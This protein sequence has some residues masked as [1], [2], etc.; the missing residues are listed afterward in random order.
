[1]AAAACVLLLGMF[2]FSGC[3]TV[4]ENQPVVSGE[5]QGT[6]PD[7]SGKT[8]TSRSY[9]K[10]EKDVPDTLNNEERTERPDV[11]K[12][13]PN[14]DADLSRTAQKMSSPKVTLGKKGGAFSGQDEPIRA[15]FAFDNADIHEV[16]DVI[17]YEHFNLSYMMDPAIRAKLS[18]HI[19]GEFTKKE[20][21]NRLNSIF[22]LSNLAIV[23]GAGNIL[24]IVN[25]KD[26]PG[27]G[28]FQNY[29]RTDYAGDIT[30]LIKL[31]YI[32]APTAE[33]H[34]KPFLSPAALSIVDP[35]NNSLIITDMQENIEKATTILGFMDEPFFQDL[36]WKIFPIEEGDSKKVANDLNGMLKS[37][38]FYTRAGMAQGGYHIIPLTTIN[39]VFVLSRWP[40]V[41]RM[42]EKWISVMDR[43]GEAGAGVYVYFVENSSAK[44]LADI[45]KQ[46]YGGEVRKNSTSKSQKIV[47]SEKG[48]EQ[49]SQGETIVSGEL[50]GE[51][52]IIPD[53][54]TNSLIFKAGR[55]DYAKISKVLNKLDI[56]SRQVL[57]NVVVAEV[58]LEET[59]EY[60][61]QWYL[62]D[63]YG[64]YSGQGML[65]IK[66]SL[67][68]VNSALG[69]STQFTYSIF[70]SADVL[71]GLVSALGKESD[72]NI[73]SSPNV[74][75][76]DNKAARIEVGEDVPTITGQVTDAN[77]GV[78]NTVQ[79]KKTGIILEVT[80]HINS[81]GLVKMELV[82][83]VSEKGSLDQE[84]QNYSILNRKVETNLVVE[85][86]QTILMGGMMKS[87]KSNSESGIPFVK[88]LPFVGYLFKGTTDEV[89]KTELIFLITPHVV[90]N[91][92]DADRI[93]REFSSKIEGVK[94]LL[95]KNSDS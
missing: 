50:S 88:D 23:R 67:K 92:K 58:T 63:H 39:A 4:A 94:K 33:Q 51:V 27:A 64:D 17:L 40:E 72:I 25:R 26:V 53:E 32:G 54:T 35:V 16:V 5:V 95:E 79:Y 68:T 85:D 77:G 56:V 46:V 43:Q 30:R 83:E 87:N 28:N 38:G 36:S 78:T 82:Q 22:Q 19:A 66:D 34:I 61:I 80:P 62:K 90:N 65:D 11:D 93:T 8:D 70:N 71:K 31:R 55:S 42:A 69:A 81:S 37:K 75:A 13:F 14:P 47:S 15:E 7:T 74:L 12:K 3:V 89:K 6:E 44:K 41:I 57:I 1:M 18:F 76:V 84:L 2:C 59:T 21:V 9:R 73:L 48:G 86:N 49:E 24:K 45:L 52:E 91:R 10:S 29:G 60:G 20:I